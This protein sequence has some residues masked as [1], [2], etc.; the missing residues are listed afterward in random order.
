M[1]STPF[2]P[3]AGPPWVAAIDRVTSMRFATPA[4]VVFWLCLWHV[5]SAERFSLEAVGF[6]SAFVATCMAYGTVFERWT[7]QLLPNTVGSTY[8]LLTG[9]FC[10]NSLLFVLTLSS[11]LGIFANVSILVAAPLVILATTA[12]A[13]P[14]LAVAKAVDERPGFV[15]LLIA[16]A[17]ATLWTRDLQPVMEARGGDVVFRAW[18]DIFIH[19]RE[20]SAFAQSHGLAS[21]S[22]IKMLGTAAPAYHFAS[23]VSTAAFSA[24]TSTSALVNFG[25]FQLPFGILL[26]ACAA[27]VLVGSVW[28]VWPGVAA[29]FAVVALPDAYEQ[30]FG[31]GYLGFHFMSQANLGM[32]YGLACVAIAWVFVLEGCRRAALGAVVMGYAFLALTL[33]YKAHLFVANAYLLLIFP[34]LYFASLARIW[35]LVGLVAS[36]AVFVV[37]I[38][39]SQQSPMVPTLRI[40]GTGAGAYM[41]ILYL[42]FDDSPLKSI[43]DWALFRHQ[44]GR[45]ID[46][47]VA[48]LLILFGTFGYWV[49]AG[50]VAFWKLKDR[51]PKLVAPFVLL[52]VAN[53]FVMSL[54]WPWTSDASA[55]LRN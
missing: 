55:R 23:Y 45:A 36:T 9:F 16:G 4:L 11:R 46:L 3:T 1:S 50:P 53:Y 2:R 20:I 10:F 7:A 48:T 15:C 43:L 35:R 18:F 52:V 40:D 25:G 21:M 8:R 41:R 51:V 33:F 49:L 44:F 5:R 6:A 12:I 38:W 24:W 29:A 42:G 13:R 17:A 47:V 34:W 31:A 32:L 26:T 54:G 14:R 27:F 22:D 30:G 39:L 28:S 37:A 19:V